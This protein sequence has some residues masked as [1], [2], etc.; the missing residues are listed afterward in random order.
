MKMSTRRRPHL[1]SLE[2]M[3]LLSSMVHAEVTHAIRPASPVALS[4]TFHVTGRQFHAPRG[5]GPDLPAFFAAGGSGNL[6][7]IGRAKAEL[8]TVPAAPGYVVV[9]L[10]GRGAVSLLTEGPLPAAG[11]SAA[12]PYAVVDGSGPILGMVNGSGTISITKAAAHGGRT[13]F[14]IRLS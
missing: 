14:D 12:S 3:L 5:H 7:G 9:L 10:T 13:S 2:P 6:A 8:V 4:G 11:P 1:E